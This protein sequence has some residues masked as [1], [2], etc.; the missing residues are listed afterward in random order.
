MH[1]HLS[2]PT[3][4]AALNDG[5]DALLTDGSAD[6]GLETAFED[7]SEEFGA[8]SSSTDLRMANAASTVPLSLLDGGFALG[9][10][11][12]GALP[13]CGAWEARQARSCCRCTPDN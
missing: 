12:E 13:H 1:A 9:N 3:T 10:L 7:L 11:A 6:F 2:P 5:S 8:T 4:V